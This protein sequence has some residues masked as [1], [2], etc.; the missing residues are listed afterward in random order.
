MAIQQLD[1]SGFRSLRDTIW[2]PSSL[3]LVVGPNGAGKSN[4]LRLLEF[5]QNSARGRL[6]E[7]VR[8]AGGMVPLL[9]NH[10]GPSFG[11]KV[12]LDPPDNGRDRS[13]AVTYELTLQQLG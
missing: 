1:V 7:T 11:W 2:R 12:R 8:Q 10:V 4:L 9:W 5:I 6:S 3:N 13:K